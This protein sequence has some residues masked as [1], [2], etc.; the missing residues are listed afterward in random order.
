MTYVSQLLLSRIFRMFKILHQESFFFSALRNA[1]DIAFGRE[2]NRLSRRIAEKSLTENFPAEYCLRTAE[3][4]NDR[5]L[6]L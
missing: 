6:F 4:S 1:G 2:I 5:P 3:L